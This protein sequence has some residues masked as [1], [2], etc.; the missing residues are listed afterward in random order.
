MEA[1]TVRSVDD[2]DT[3]VG[4]KIVE[5]PHTEIITHFFSFDNNSDYSLQLLLQLAC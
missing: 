4:V 2:V 5:S 1:K 3:A